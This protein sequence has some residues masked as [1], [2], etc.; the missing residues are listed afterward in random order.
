LKI[1]P[2]KMKRFPFALDEILLPLAG[3]EPVLAKAGMPTGG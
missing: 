2:L 3:E 1:V